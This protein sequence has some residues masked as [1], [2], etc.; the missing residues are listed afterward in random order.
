MVDVTQH[1]TLRIFGAS[2]AAFIAITIYVL[3]AKWWNGKLTGLKAWA[4]EPAHDAAARF[5]VGVVDWL[6]Q[7]PTPARFGWQLLM[8]GVLALG[9]TVFVAVCPEIIKEA[10]E[11]RW[12]RELNQPL[13]EYRSAMYSQAF[14]RNLC[15]LFY[16]VG[17]GYTLYYIGARGFEAIQYLMW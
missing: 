15:A 7:L 5:W 14:W 12:T 17:G 9:A 16:A 6:P 11:S 13:I 3:M 2:Y 8:L 10:T 4:A 1:G